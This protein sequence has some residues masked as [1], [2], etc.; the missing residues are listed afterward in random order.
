MKVIDK[1]NRERLLE[2]LELPNDIRKYDINKQYSIIHEKIEV[3]EKSIFIDDSIIEHKEYVP[4]KRQDAT[5]QNALMNF[6]TK[7]Y[8]N[9]YFE[10]IDYIDDYGNREN[11]NFFESEMN[12][13]KSLLRGINKKIKKIINFDDDNNQSS[14]VIKEYGIDENGKEFEETRKLDSSENMMDEKEFTKTFGIDLESLA[15][16]VL[17]NDE[18]KSDNINT[19]ESKGVNE[20]YNGISGIVSIKNIIDY[21]PSQNNQPN[22]NENKKTNIILPNEYQLMKSMPEDPKGSVVYGKQTNN[23]TC[24]AMIY[25]INNNE[26]IPYNSEEIINGIHNT[27]KEDQGLIEVNIGTTKGN[28]KFA[29]SI[30][31][32]KKEP[33]GIQYTLSL[34]IS[35][36][37]YVIHIQAFFDEAGMTGQREAIVMS[38]L[39]SEGKINPT[40]MNGWMKDP[41]DETYNKGL[42]MNIAEKEEYD[43]IFPQHPLSEARKF[44]KIVIENN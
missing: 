8:L 17:T 18:S 28:R 4:S 32:T 35:M 11:C 2:F 19:N 38:K 1:S 25:N 12:N 33:S 42:R 24:M 39:I 34:Q 7:D 10:I 16:D 31:K 6:Q 13:I 23:A 21:L 5:W 44:I 43:A 26:A 22:N 27:L 14:I 15:D 30:V 3:L 9:A 20:K 29:Y 40:E 36:I 41:Y 37:E